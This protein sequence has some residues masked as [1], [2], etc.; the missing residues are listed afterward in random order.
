MRQNHPRTVLGSRAMMLVLVA[1]VVAVS[2]MPGCGSS[3]APLTGRSAR[4]VQSA[5]EALLSEDYTLGL[6]F[7]DSA[8]MLAESRPEPHFLRGRLLFEL[9]QYDAAADEYRKVKELAPTYPGLGVNLGN[10]AF[11][12]QLYR[13]ALTH[14]RTE[15]TKGARVYHAIGGALEQLGSVD[16]ALVSYEIAVGAD[17]TYAPAAYSLSRMLERSGDVSRALTTASS[18]VVLDGENTAFQL[19]LARMQLQNQQYPDAV[20]ILDPLVRQEPWNYT[21]RFALGQALQRQGDRARGAEELTRADSVRAALAASERLELQARDAP[22]AV[23]F[24][25]YGESLRQ[26]GR[27]REAL[28]AYGRAVALA[29]AD[30]VLKSNLATLYLQIGRTE[31]GVSRLIKIAGEHPEVLEPWL[32]LAV[33]FGRT[34]QTARARLFLGRAEALAPDNPIVA[35]VKALLAD[36]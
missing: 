18:A 24:A 26:M 3:P 12:R 16:S 23:G 36:Q 13:Q 19:Q 31:E 35:R 4:L 33:H 27:H 1:V 7:A 21:A 9:N 20:R 17:P 5:Q 10:V 22:S 6:A 14:F 32:N 29:P 28:R 11:A 30:I 25:R 2:T 8:V 34:N 15:S